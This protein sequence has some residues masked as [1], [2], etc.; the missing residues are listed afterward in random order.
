[1]P[2]ANPGLRNIRVVDLS[3]GT[4]GPYCSFLLGAF[5]A[6]VIKVELPVEGDPSRRWGPFPADE[7]H[8]E[9][10]AAFLYL[11]RNKRGITLDLNQEEGRR[12]L[13]ELVEVAD[14]LVESFEPG[15]L[16]SLGLGRDVLH[17]HNPA[18]IISSVTNFGQTGPYSHYKGGELVLDALSGWA[19]ITGDP[20]REPLKPALRQVFMIAVM[21]L[22]D[23][24]SQRVTQ[25]ALMA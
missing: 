23:L 8:L 2:T 7:P 24:K 16:D 9:K 17:Q 21:S 11:N 20:H 1:M 25:T 3:Q 14:A 4:S 6:E 15:G 5:G 22:G 19:Q 12:L 13:L 10:S 18:I